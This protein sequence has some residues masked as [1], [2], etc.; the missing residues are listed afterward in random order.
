MHSPF[1]LLALLLVLSAGLATLNFHVLKWPVTVGLLAGACAGTVCLIALD[2]VLPGLGSKAMVRGIVASIDFPAT[3]LRGFLAFLLFAGALAVNSADLF[4]RKWTILALATLGTLLSTGLIGGALLLVSRLLGLALPLSWCLVFGALISPTDPVSVLDVLR[5][6]GMPPT[7]QAVVA[8][9]SLFNDGVGV[10]L[11]TLML[12]YAVPGEAAETG[13]AHVAMLFVVQGAGGALVGLGLAYLA[14]RVMRGV[15]DAGVELFISLALAAGSYSLAGRLGTSGPIAVV[16]AGIL[17]GNLGMDSAM[18]QASRAY[19][20]MFWRLVEEILNALLFLMIGLEIA[21]IDLDARF[22]LAMLVMIPIVLLA[23]WLSVA[24]SAWPL[25]M[26]LRTRG[27]LL[28]LTWGG[29]R[30]GLSVAM[31]LSLPEGPAKAPI[32]TIAYGIVVFTIVVQGLTLAALA[33]RVLR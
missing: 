8:G 9:E 1:D 25:N 17:V 23:R 5:R 33:R 4:A 20:S 7:L 32:L 30:G 19:L 2:A 14:V 31:A 24:A 21:A 10:V 6:V 28:I 27:P 29:L 18:S 12:A 16:A 26:R 11:F 15:D 22:F 13:V 3:L